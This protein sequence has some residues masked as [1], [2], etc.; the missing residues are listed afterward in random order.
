METNLNSGGIPPSAMAL[1]D[2]L[3][4]K[5]ATSFEETMLSQSQLELLRQLE[6]EVDDY[7][8]KSSRLTA[9]QMRFKTMTA[10]EQN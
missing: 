7:L 6:K 4:R 3:S 10:G 5:L 9:L 8:D 2:S 1:K